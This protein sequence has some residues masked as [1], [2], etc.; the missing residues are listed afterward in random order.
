[1]NAKQYESITG[2]KPEQDDLERANCNKHGHTFCGTCPD[3]GMPRHIGCD[4]EQDRRR[5]ER[6]QEEACIA[7][8]SDDEFIRWINR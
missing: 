3:C 5:E 7:A 1:M 4:H 6:R 2:H 8:M